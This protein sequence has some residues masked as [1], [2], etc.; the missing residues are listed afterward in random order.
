MK[1]EATKRQAGSES[2]PFLLKTLLGLAIPTVLEEVLSTVIQYA[3]TA[4]VG[5]LGEEATAAVSVTST[6]GWLIGAVIY[7]AGTG[8]LTLVSRAYGAEDR[9]SAGELARLAEKLTLL[10]G[11]PLTILCLL[12]SPFLPVWMGAAPDVRHPASVYFAIICLPMVFRTATAILGSAVR[13]TQ[14]TKT[15]ML[16]SLLANVINIV[17]DYIFIYPLGW[18]VTGAAVA[19]AIAFSIGGLLDMILFRRT[20]F[21]AEGR[22]EAEAAYRLRKA[23]A[24]EATADAERGEKIR[25][26]AAGGEKQQATRKTAEEEKRRKETGQYLR[27]LATISLPVVATSVTSCLGYVVFAALVSR[28]GTTVFAAHSIAVN[29]ET[30][31][32]IP[33]YGLRTATAALVGAAIGEKRPDK[34]KRYCGLSTVLTMGLMFVNG[35]VL[36]AVAEPLMEVFT[37]SREV[38]ELGAVCL[39]IV[40][41]TE[42]FYGLMVVMEGIFYVTGNTKWPFVVET[43]SMWGI[44]IACTAVGIHAFAFSL[45]QVW[46][47]MIVD[48]IAKATLLV[49]PVIV[50]ALRR[51]ALRLDLA[52]P[53]SA[54]VL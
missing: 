50:P 27:E 39:R 10:I 5:H 15:P 48:N 28:M 35:I 40:A 51:R 46:Y 22:K 45:N 16:I 54:D 29:A 30:I 2:L 4:M 49:L 9:K 3:D 31:F 36:F 38:A 20:P 23:R 13:A 34:L 37:S 6:I 21:L 24:D 41:F 18:G 12:L 17:L 43:V 25:A 14:N 11:I 52:D 33:G 19:S 44:R 47:C 26:R 42:P 7:A 1:R 8:V 32:Y 53:D